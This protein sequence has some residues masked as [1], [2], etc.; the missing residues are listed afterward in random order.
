MLLDLRVSQQHWTQLRRH[1][2]H[3]FRSKTAPETAA[4]GV[5]GLCR[6]SDRTE[7]L[8]A[9]LFWPADGDLKIAKHGRVELSSTYV[10]RAHLYMRE[11]KLAGLVVFHTHPMSDRHVAFS[12]FDNIEEPLLADNLAE[13]YPGTTL[14]SLVIGKNSQCGRDW[15]VP[16]E[17]EPMHTLIVVGESISHIPLN[18][19][20]PVPPPR[21]EGIFDSALTLTSAG[22][23]ALLRDL[24]PAI[25]GGSGTGSLARE[26]LTRAGCR[27]PIM[28]DD[29]IAEERNANP[30]LH[31]TAKDI[32]RRTPKVEISRRATDELKMDFRLEAV[33]GNVLDRDTLAKLRDADIIFG[34]VDK[35][36][37]RKLLS[38]F[39]FRYLR[40]YVDVGTE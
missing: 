33:Q 22:A 11:N 36:Y 4:L 9:K 21:P 40:P 25:V 18:G 32:A 34:C 26:L 27:F 1:F 39:S 28:I 8:V 20:P 6:R 3:S 37:P 19:A 31:L 38:E 12:P 7:Y 30:I 15:T 24:R 5:L 10:R 17:C 35:A 23:L 13:L 14:V 16:A 29:D 2:Q